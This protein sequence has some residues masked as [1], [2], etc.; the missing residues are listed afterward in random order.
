MGHIELAAPV[1]H[2]WFTKSLPSR[3]ATMLDMT[4]KN[5]E[6]VFDELDT[7]HSGQLS[8]TEFAEA[9]RQVSVATVTMYALRWKTV[10]PI[11]R[12]TVS[13]PLPILARAVATACRREASAPVSTTVTKTAARTKMIFVHGNSTLQ[14]SGNP[15]PVVVGT[16]VYPVMTASFV[17]KPS[18]F[19]M[20]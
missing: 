10:A 11:T 5:L 9:L 2:I 15:S 13:R 19:V 12:T 8:Y 17:S 14:R 1:A 16:I 3:I 7:D 6:K 4:V 18:K 20:A